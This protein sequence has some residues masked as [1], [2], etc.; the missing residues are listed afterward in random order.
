MAYNITKMMWEPP[1]K[2][3]GDE[4]IPNVEWTMDKA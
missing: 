2:K 4:K 3:K 1:C